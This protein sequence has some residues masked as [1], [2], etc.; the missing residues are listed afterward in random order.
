MILKDYFR[1]APYLLVGLYLITIFNSFIE[2]SDLPGPFANSM[3]RTKN[4]L[5]AVISG[6]VA[7]KLSKK[8]VY[9]EL[10]MQKFFFPNTKITGSATPSSVKTKVDLLLGTSY[11]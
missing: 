2:Y 9:I 11:F 3:G 7:N 1:K 4:S 8:E 6:I 10:E 5:A